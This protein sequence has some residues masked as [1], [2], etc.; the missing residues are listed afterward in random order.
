MKKLSKLTAQA[1]VAVSLLSVA[2]PTFASTAQASTIE[3][4]Q[5]QSKLNLSTQ[6][7]LDPYVTV[8]NNHYVLSENAKKVVSEEEYNAAK[9]VIAQTNAA[10]ENSGSVINQ[11][12]KVATNDFTLSNDENSVVSLNKGELATRRK[13]YH[14]GVNKVTYH[15]NYIRVYL[16]KTTTQA[17]AAGA[18]GGLGALIANY[19]SG[20]LA[21]FAVGAISSSVSALVGSSIKGGVWVDY[22]FLEIGRASCRE[23]V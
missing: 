11:N 17:V 14:Y 12:T 21:T 3:S 2:A 5:T 15:W 10:V 18:V 4:S 19:V 8:E 1:A 23:R 7:K 9:Q 22:N 20:G 13:K 6:K 16:N